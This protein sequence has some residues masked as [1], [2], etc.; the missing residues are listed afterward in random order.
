MSKSG[1]VFQIDD[2]TRTMSKGGGGWLA[3]GLHTIDKL[4]MIHVGLNDLYIYDNLCNIKK[5]GR[6]GESR[7]R[8][9]WK[10]ES[11]RKREGERATC[12][13]TDSLL[14]WLAGS[15]AARA[16]L[17]KKSKVQILLSWPNFA[18]QLGFLR[19]A[20]NFA[21]HLEFLRF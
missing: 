20:R 10:T 19:S 1:G 16:K 7:D 15:L 18:S 2:V 6:R 8:E 14:G 17:S 5:E 21:S 13:Q 3:T 11:E 12:I 4:D 9:K